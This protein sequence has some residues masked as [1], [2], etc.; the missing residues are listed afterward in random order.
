MLHRLDLLA[1]VLWAQRRPLGDA[2]RL[3]LHDIEARGDQVLP[4]EPSRAH[5][6]C[7]VAAILDLGCLV[8]RDFEGP[9]K[10]ATQPHVARLVATFAHLGDSIATCRHLLSG[11]RAF[12]HICRH[13]PLLPHRGGLEANVPQFARVELTHAHLVFGEICIAQLA[14]CE[15]TQPK[16][17][18]HKAAFA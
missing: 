6:P 8:S 17:A 7:H 14:C 2:A 13:K 10:D 12:A 16:V 11:V 1:L 4:R 5:L 15:A 18:W 3:Q 9:G